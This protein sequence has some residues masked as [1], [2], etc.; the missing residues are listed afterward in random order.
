MPVGVARGAWREAACEKRR[1]WWEWP[2]NK[3]SRQVRMLGV[4][5][6]NR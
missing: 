6:R 5:F 3:R 2:V 1:P 4:V